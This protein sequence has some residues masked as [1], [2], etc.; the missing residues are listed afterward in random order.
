MEQDALLELQSG[1]LDD[2]SE[3]SG[4]IFNLSG[5]MDTMEQNDVERRINAEVYNLDGLAEDDD[6]GERDGDN[7]GDYN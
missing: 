6:F 2:V 1:G 3:F 4:E 7:L 5:L